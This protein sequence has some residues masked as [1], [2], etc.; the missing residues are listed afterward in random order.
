MFVGTQV[1]VNDVFYAPLKKVFIYL[2]L[3]PIVLSTSSLALCRRLLCFETVHRGSLPLLL[4][5]SVPID[6]SRHF[7]SCVS[8]SGAMI[9]GIA[10]GTLSTLQRAFVGEVN[11]LL[12]GAICIYHAA[13]ANWFILEV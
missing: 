5:P 2:S 1:Q 12:P 7:P 9:P 13:L 6:C 3:T 8:S 4:S 11:W 10:F